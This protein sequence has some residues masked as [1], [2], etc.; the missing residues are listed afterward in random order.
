VH[1]AAVQNRVLC[2]RKGCKK[3]YLYLPAHLRFVKIWPTKHTELMG[4][5][6]EG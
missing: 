2:K 1:C 4:V 5:K 6:I 3:K